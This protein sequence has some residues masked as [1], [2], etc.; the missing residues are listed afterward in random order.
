MSVEGQVTW[1]PL[2]A[3]SFSFLFQA[4]SLTGTKKAGF[5]LTFKMTKADLEKCK[6]V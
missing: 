2:C 3:C 4:Q 6:K 1:Q 5:P